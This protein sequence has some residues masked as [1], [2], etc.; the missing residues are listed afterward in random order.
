MR[1]FFLTGNIFVVL[2]T[3]I[4]LTLFFFSLQTLTTNNLI[5]FF[6]TDIYL[7]SPYLQLPDNIAIQ[8]SIHVLNYC[9]LYEALFLIARNHSIL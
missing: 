1:V 8:I 4:H 3:R 6:D 7:N 2:V 9:I 5:I